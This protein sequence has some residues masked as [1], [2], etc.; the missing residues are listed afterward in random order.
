MNRGFNDT[1]FIMIL[2]Q[3]N[4]LN[5]GIPTCFI[6]QRRDETDFHR[7]QIPAFD[8]E[9][10]RPGLRSYEMTVPDSHIDL[11]TWFGSHERKKRRC[12]V[13][14]LVTLSALV[15]V[16][17]YSLHQFYRVKSGQIAQSFTRKPGIR[18]RSTTL[19]SWGRNKLP[20]L[21]HIHLQ[22]LRLSLIHFHRNQQTQYPG[23][24][25]VLLTGFFFSF[26]A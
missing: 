19:N 18:Y 16:I 21:S 12:L 17:R 10:M 5:R 14:G 11:R 15:R 1:S 3:R 20:L 2:Y 23:G 7:A 4:L 22:L 26:L 9:Y 24:M 25:R 8:S 13:V 6:Q